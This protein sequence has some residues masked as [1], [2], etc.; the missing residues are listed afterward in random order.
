MRRTVMHEFVDGAVVAGIDGSSSAVSAAVWAGAEARRRDRPLRLVQAYALP[1]VG[2]P[3][4]VGSQDQVRAGLVER[5]E[6]WLAGART[7]VLA[8]H[9]GLEI[10][11]AAR[12]WSPVTTLVQESEHA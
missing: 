12:V 8:D 9:P 1:Q 6:G 3:D 7:E 2:A 11:T 4:V 10:V 5:A